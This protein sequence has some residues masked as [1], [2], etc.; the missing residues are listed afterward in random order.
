[1]PAASGD[2]GA[3][4][5]RVFD[6]LAY[7]V[8]RYLDL[9]EYPDLEAL[10]PQLAAA[11]F[12]ADEINRA[13]DWLSGLKQMPGEAMVGEARDNGPAAIRLYSAA[14]DYKLAPEGR[15]YLQFLEDAGVLDWHRREVV[16][17]RIVALADAE[18]ALEQIK[19]IVL[20]VLWQHG[21]PLNALIVD[22]LLA[23]HGRVPVH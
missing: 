15:G 22:E 1:M 16:I 12:D 20:V 21:Q 18:M 17:E 5:K 10:P 3:S 9:G 4:P 6:I 23:P 13:L 19:L 7:L 2:T 14:E 11:G 8:D